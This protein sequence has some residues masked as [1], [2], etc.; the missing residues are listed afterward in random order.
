MPNE[1]LCPLVSVIVPVYHV[2]KELRKCLDS[3]IHQ[4]FQN[5]EL[6]LINDGGNAEDTTICEE[7]AASNPRIIYRTQPNQGLS[8]ARNLG[9]SLARG[10]WIMFVDSDDWVHKNFIQKALEAV[11]GKDAQMVIFDL[12]YTTSNGQETWPHRSGLDAGVYPSNVVLQE[13]LSGQIVC[14]AWNKL[15]HRDLWNGISF[16]VGELWEDDAIIHEIIDRCDKIVIIHDV[17]YY[18]RN[19]E[20]SITGIAS[21]D[22]KQQYWLF[23]QRKR[24]FLYLRDRHPEMMVIENRNMSSA[25]VQY[26]ASLVNNYS[27]TE[28]RKISSW[29]RDQHMS[30]ENWSIKLRF[31]T[32]LLIFSPSLFLFAIILRNQLKKI[33]FK[34]SHYL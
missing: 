11:S 4:S 21:R 23:I 20:D 14:Y 8:A 1:Q 26:A 30:G 25:A 9:L 22:N 15:Y 12:I 19:R 17:L 24:R 34:I 7:Y 5:F 6:L 32:Y 3:L 29:I 31:A 16:P 2:E 18:K 10:Q 13:R 28:V 33:R 27:L